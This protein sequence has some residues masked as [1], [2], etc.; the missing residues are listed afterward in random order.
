[1]TWIMRLIIVLSSAKP[2]VPDGDLGQSQT[3]GAASTGQKK[4]GI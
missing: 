4:H 3:S 1:M 2:G